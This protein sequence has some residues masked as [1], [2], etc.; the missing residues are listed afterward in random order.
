MS[1]TNADAPVAQREV[2]LHAQN[3]SKHFGGLK[4]VDGVSLEIRR[5]TIQGLIGPNGAGKTT[6]F[7]MIAGIYQP[8]DGQIIFEGQVIQG[9]AGNL[10][11]SGSLRPDQIAARGIARTFQNIR[12]FSNMTALENVLIGMHSKLQSNAIGAILRLRSVRDE[13]RNARIRARELLDYVGLRGKWDETAKNLS[14]GDQRRLEVARA[15]GA[16]PHLLLL[17]EP[18]AGMNPNETARMTRFIDRMRTDLNLTIL[19]IEHDMKVVMGISD[20]VA[21]LDHGQKI[22]DGS[23][24]EVQRNPN[25]VEAYLGKA[26]AALA[27]SVLARGAAEQRPDPTVAGGAGG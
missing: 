21:V 17:D 7:N 25:V 4:A 9:G 3:V 13:E 2:V 18:T 22:A 16:E 24:A 10:M 12:L 6:F 1:A 27:E 14:Y 26:G 20:K 11:R 19:L 23:P 5:G 15:L 8:T